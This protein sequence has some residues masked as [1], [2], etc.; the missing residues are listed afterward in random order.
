MTPGYGLIMGTQKFVDRIKSIYVP[1]RPHREV[2]QQMGIVGR[3]DPKMIVDQA[4][5]LLSCDIE[6]YREARRLYGPDKEIRDLFVYLLWQRGGYTN[7]EIGEFFGVSY[8]AVSH[9][10]K[11]VKVQL[12]TDRIYKQ[13]Y[14]KVNSQ[15]KM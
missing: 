10:V 5:A 12:K 13:K 14:E 11:K 9:I 7:V 4:S 2:P 3:M 1:E 8:T 6:E 15:I